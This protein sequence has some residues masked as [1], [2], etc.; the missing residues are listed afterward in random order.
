MITEELFEKEICSKCDGDFGVCEISGCYEPCYIEYL[1]EQ[2]KQMFETLVT[3]I[4][5]LKDAGT[6]FILGIETVESITGKK[7]E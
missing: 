7:M 1:E 5:L 2:N 6:E 3:A 4:E